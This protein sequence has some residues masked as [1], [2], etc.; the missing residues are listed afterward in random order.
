MHNIHLASYYER[1]HTIP[2]DKVCHTCFSELDP[3]GE[4]ILAHPRTDG[5]ANS[6]GKNEWCHIHQDCLEQWIRTKKRPYG[7]S[8]PNCNSNINYTRIFPD[9]Y[10]P[11]VDEEFDYL[12][13][14]IS[15]PRPHVP[16]TT[17][18]ITRV[19]TNFYLGATLATIGGVCGIATSLLGGSLAARS[20]ISGA[21]VVVG[22]IT[23]PPALFALSSPSY[24]RKEVA[25]LFL[26]DVPAILAG[27]AT[28]IACANL[29]LNFF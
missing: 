11:S 14:E 3:V 5:K 23:V 19:K 24:S 25:E 13:K 27:A 7:V 29:V 9:L 28:A 16:N 20:A 4:K 26:L 21:Q 12:I 22:G 8:C 10:R 17:P 1:S 2:P 15:T 6:I 18:Y